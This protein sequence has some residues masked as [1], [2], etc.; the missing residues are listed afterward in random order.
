[1]TCNIE[2]SNMIAAADATFRASNFH[3]MTPKM[4]AAEMR[5]SGICRALRLID[6][7]VSEIYETRRAATRMG[8]SHLGIYDR[9]NQ[10]ARAVWCR[11]DRAIDAAVS[12]AA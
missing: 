2:I 12:R 3:N 10:R 6:E 1:M 11:Y 9:L 5:A 8:Q 4:I 7:A